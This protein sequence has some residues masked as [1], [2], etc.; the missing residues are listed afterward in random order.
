MFHNIILGG[1]ENAC[2]YEGKIPAYRG[3]ANSR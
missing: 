2:K 1:M 3:A